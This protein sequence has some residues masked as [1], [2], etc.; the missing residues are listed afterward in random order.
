MRT[1][2]LVNGGM[3]Y[4]IL[5]F[6]FYFYSSKIKLNQTLKFDGMD[7]IKVKTITICVVDK[8]TLGQQLLGTSCWYRWQS[9]KSV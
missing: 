2:I 7:T 8:Y 4:I 9:Y 6:D 1:Q 5:K 3:A